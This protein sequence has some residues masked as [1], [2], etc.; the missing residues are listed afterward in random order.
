MVRKIRLLAQ[1]VFTNQ[2]LYLKL[3]NSDI[4]NFS[5]PPMLLRGMLPLFRDVDEDLK[6]I[7]DEEHID[8][9]NKNVAKRPPY[10]PFND[11]D[12][13]YPC[14]KDYEPAIQPGVSCA[15][16]VL[17]RK[18]TGSIHLRVYK[19]SNTT[20][21]SPVIIYFPSRGTNPLA[22]TYEHHVISL[23]TKLTNS[24]TISVGYRV[25]P[26]FPLSLHD[27]FA[28]IDWVRSEVP[29]VSL[30][31]YCQNNYNGRL[32]AVLGTGIGGSLAASI[33]ATEG[34]EAGIIA[35]G[36]WLPIVDWAFDPL[37]GIPES[38]LSSIPRSQSL[39]EKYSQSEAGAVDP[40]LLSTYSKLADNP[41]LSSE[42]LKTIRSH[43]L[44]TPED[45][46]DPFV[47]PLYRFSSSGVNIWTDLIS[48]VES[49]LLADPENPPAWIKT[50][51]GTIF[52]RGPRRPVSYPPLNLIGK[53]TVPMMRIVSAEGDILHQQITEYV[54]AARS[55]M[56]PPKSKTIEDIEKEETREL[57]KTHNNDIFE[58]SEGLKSGGEK[59][60]GWNF[61][62]EE[63]TEEEE[64]E[65]VKVQGTSQD[66]IKEPETTGVVVEKELQNSS[67]DDITGEEEINPKYAKGAEIYI[68][69]EIIPKAGH[70]LITAAGE[71]SRGIKEVENM[72]AWINSVFES[73][74]KRAQHWK[75]Q[76][77]R[78]RKA[79]E[80]ALN[81]RR[82][83]ASKL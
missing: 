63:V 39:L 17:S 30:E 2:T 64:G 73:E 34:R 82:K 3:T 80:E 15:D 16:F 35:T 37:P 51:P 32:M 58:E 79:L 49:E 22:T 57:G 18:A 70:C 47:S 53:L 42:T 65:Q 61:E 26:P 14:E 9:Y 56:F 6:D 50:L 25:S 54:H 33:G 21:R 13:Q 19:V 31:T 78:I 48:Q 72:A 60:V 62:E 59:G 67:W 24:T 66:D 27:A 41:F 4:L 10:N 77:E 1:L 45:F 75:S 69:H 20:S 71:I 46:T 68:Q 43:Y 5:S 38:D 52:K 23:L 40:D 7:Y 76:Q 83:R 55:S 81:A 44:A 12:G 74:P 29:I 8:F 36:A 28:A 11:L